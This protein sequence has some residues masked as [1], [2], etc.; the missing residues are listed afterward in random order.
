MKRDA[1]CATEVLRLLASDPMSDLGPALEAARRLSRTSNSMC[2]ATR[3]MN[4]L[5]FAI[6]V[7]SMYLCRSCYSQ[8]TSTVA[9]GADPGALWFKVEHPIK[10]KKAR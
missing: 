9:I 2:A 8:M 4:R 6:A 10:H 3:Q 5:V 1:R 7:S